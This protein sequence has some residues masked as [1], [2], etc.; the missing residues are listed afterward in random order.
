MAGSSHRNDDPYFKMRPGEINSV[1]MN[2]K[3]VSIMNLEQ[4]QFFIVILTVC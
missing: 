3:T 2:R 1:I 4:V